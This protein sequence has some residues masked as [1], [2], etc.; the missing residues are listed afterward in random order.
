MWSGVGSSGSRAPP[1]NDTC[2]ACRRRWAG[3]RVNSRRGS[4]A[5]DDERSEHRRV[6]Q[7]EPREV[8]LPPGVLLERL[9]ELGEPRVHQRDTRSAADVAPVSRPASGRS[10]PACRSARRSTPSP[11][12]YTTNTSVVRGPEV[13]E[14][15][16]NREHPGDEGH[17]RGHR[18]LPHGERRGGVPEVAELEQAGRGGGGNGEQERV[19]GRVLAPEPS[20]E[21]PGEGGAGAARAGDER[22]G[23]PQADDPPVLPGH[24]VESTRVAGGPLRRCEEHGEADHRRGHDVQ[25]AQG[26]LDGVLEHEAQHH[27]RDRSDEDEPGQPRL[28]GAKRLPALDPLH[29]GPEQPDDVVTEE[30]QHRGDRPQLDDGVESR[31]GVLPAEQLGGDA[32]VGGRADGQELGDA[33]DQAEDDG[34]E[35]THWRAALMPGSGRGGQ[36]AVAAPVNARA[37]GRV[38]PSEGASVRRQA[39]GGPVDLEVAKCADL[40]RS[41]QGDQGGRGHENGGFGRGAAA[42]G[43]LPGRGGDGGGPR[44][45]HHPARPGGELLHAAHV[46]AAGHHP[47]GLVAGG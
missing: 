15:A 29:P 11:S 18:Q 19:A 36:V 20:P 21:P 44:L 5:P 27:H 42:R 6:P 39:H 14:Q 16:A 30:D 31:P 2:P 40:G 33:L 25:R 46:R 7:L 10:R 37:G 22:Q 34:A 45:G 43:L 47:G 35:E 4:A 8:Q 1:G 17:R 32:E 23:L 12:R 9:G 3:R 24:V 41:N 38:E 26:G 28:G 13:P